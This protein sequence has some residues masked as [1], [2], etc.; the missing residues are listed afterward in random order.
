MVPQLLKDAYWNDM[1]T[2]MGYY[3]NNAHNFF[4]HQLLTIGIVG[5]VSYI[6]LLIALIVKAI[7]KPD[8]ADFH[9]S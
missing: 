7:R 3:F 5:V 4:L 8:I 9:S 6:A 1:K 2:Q